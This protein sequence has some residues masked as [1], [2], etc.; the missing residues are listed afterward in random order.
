MKG[1]SDYCF[2][3]VAL[4]LVRNGPNEIWHTTNY[5]GIRIIFY[6]EFARVLLFRRIIMFDTASRPVH[7][8][9]HKNVETLRRIQA[10]ELGHGIAILRKWIFV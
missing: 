5:Y 4:L 1:S 9:H 3:V 10:A 7:M 2:F 8:V 6:F